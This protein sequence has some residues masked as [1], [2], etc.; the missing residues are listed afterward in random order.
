MLVFLVRYLGSILC[1][2]T[3]FHTIFDFENTEKLSKNVDQILK[4]QPQVAENGSVI[5]T[6]FSYTYKCIKI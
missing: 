1:S 5:L 2:F 3:R 4:T 6:R